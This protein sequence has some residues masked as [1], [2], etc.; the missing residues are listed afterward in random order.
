MNNVMIFTILLL[1][2]IKVKMK[3]NYQIYLNFMNNV[4]IFTIL[5]LCVRKVKKDKLTKEKK[6]Q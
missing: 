3:E 5:L 6:E 4:M 2:A 1:C